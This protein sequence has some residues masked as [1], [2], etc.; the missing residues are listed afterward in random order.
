MN[1]CFVVPTS[2]ADQAVRL[3]VCLETLGVKEETL[4]GVPAPLRL[5]VAVTCYWLRMASPEPDLMLL[6]ALL[7]VMV[8]GELNRR[9]GSDTGRWHLW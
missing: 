7:M 8:Q 2:Q 5:P 3:Q 9:E 6:K 4:E 1:I